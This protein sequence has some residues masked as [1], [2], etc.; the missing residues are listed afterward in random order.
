[1]TLV[2][3]QRVTTRV[4]GRRVLSRNEAAPVPERSSKKWYGG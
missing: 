3:Y 1:M 4:N 2:V